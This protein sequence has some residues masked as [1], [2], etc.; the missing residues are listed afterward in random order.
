M[1]WIGPTFG[2]WADSQAEMNAIIEFANEKTKSLDEWKAYAKKLEASLEKV[3][4][5]YRGKVG[6]EAAQA[7]LKNLALD[8]LKKLDPANRLLDP[9]YRKKIGAQARDDSAKALKNR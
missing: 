5:M 8:E 9:E 2:M 7:Q 6:D 1:T 4:A 3:S